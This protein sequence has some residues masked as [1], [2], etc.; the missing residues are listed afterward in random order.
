MSAR[1]W[2]ARTGLVV[3]VG[4]LGACAEGGTPEEPGG[5]AGSA[6]PTATAGADPTP[7]EASPTAATSSAP[8]ASPKP[9]AS[10]NL[11]KVL[12][13]TRQ[14]TIVRTASF[15][16]GISLPDKGQ[17]GEVDGDEGRQLFV[18]T[19]LAG[20]TFLIKSYKR[21]SKNALCWQSRNPGDGTPLVVEGAAC[22]EGNE[23]QR[24]E[25]RR[26][27]TSNEAYLISNQDALLR[28]SQQHGLILEELGDGPPEDTFRLIDN[29]AAPN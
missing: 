6:T 20:D 25:I 27:Q 26:A 23:R 21:G 5:A 19:P 22:D 16:G 8:A 9:T 29:G 17:L 11:P 28:T 15:E 2:L 10:R 14:V 24:F 13:G 4:A 7:T 18:P 12:S 1:A 3:L